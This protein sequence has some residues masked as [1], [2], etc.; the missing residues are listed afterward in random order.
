MKMRDKLLLGGF[1]IALVTYVLG[2]SAL[3]G[4]R[5][6]GQ[7]FSLLRKDTLP[8]ASALLELKRALSSVVEGVDRVITS[9]DPKLTEDVLGDIS[10]AR[11]CV[12]DH[13]AQSMRIT[14]GEPQGVIEIQN[15]ADGII[16]LAEQALKLVEEGVE[17]PSLEEIQRRIHSE[18]QALAGVLDERFSANMRKLGTA[19]EN[20]CRAETSGARSVILAIAAA[21][22][23]AVGFAYA[24]ANWI[25][26]PIYLLRRGSER[27]GSG[28]FAHRV[29]IRTGDEIEQLASEFNRMAA[30]VAEA[31]SS[32]EKKVA[33]RTADV[34]KI[35]EQL[36]TEIAE[37][38]ETE[39]ALGRERDLLRT[40]IDTSPDPIY[41]K[42]T[43]SRFLVGNAAVARL[44]G[45]KTPD[46]LIGKTDFDFYPEELA[47]FYHE[48]ERALFESGQPIIGR[49]EPV[50][51]PAG[52]RTWVSTSKVLLRDSGG[53]I[54][55]L[56]GSGRDIT[57]QK[58]AEEALRNSEALYHSLVESLP[59]NVFRKDSEGRFT[60]GNKLFC[61]TLGRPLREFIG[62]TDFDFYPRELAEKYRQDDR[63]VMETGKVFEDIEE[64]QK[65]DGERIYVQVLKSPVRNFSG[66]VIGTQGIFWDVTDRKKAEEAL[67]NS[68]A[69][70]HSLVE[71]LPL[72]IFRK[73]S[74]GGF[75]FGNKLFCETLGKPP[76]EFIGKTDFD[77]YP[78]ELAEKYRRDDK[79]VMETGEVFEDVEEHQK[80][81]GEKIYVQVVKTPVQNFSGEIIGTQGIFWDVTDRKRA[82]EALVYERY[83]LESLMDNLPDSI[84][85]KD[86]RSRFTRINR[87]LAQRFGLSDPQGALGKTDF[88]FFTE[89]H[90]RPAFEDE[91]EIV[92][93]G[94]P[95]V[96]KEEKETWPNGRVTWVSTTKLPLRDREGRIV[97]TF[98]VSRDITDR[99]RAEEELSKTAAELARSNAE[100]EQFA[101]VASHDLQEP[102]R[103][104]ASYTQLLAKRYSRKLSQEADEFIAYIVDGATRMQNLIGALLAYSRVGT[105]GKSFEPTD[106][107]VA[108][109]RAL[110]NLQL[111]IEES[112]AA[113]TKDPLPT[114]NADPLQLCQLFQNLVSNAIKFRGT[115]RPR[116]HVSAERNMNEWKFSVRDNGIGIEPGYIGRIFV[117]FQRLHSRGEYPGTGIG[118]AICKKI[119]ERH[120]GR[121]WVES[122]PGEGSTF[123]FT[124][125][126]TG[127]I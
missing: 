117:V 92:R 72:N 89:D 111:A 19:E 107:N 7:E 79:K 84:Y 47:R 50:V 38:R 26:K 32:L 66:E 33:D 5:R 64:H 77:F 73:D 114:V 12:Q 67:R 30:R 20:L 65:P 36:K 56:V 16:A 55:G 110:A 17:E 106:C 22:A 45:A 37:R 127:G 41:V 101:Y 27:I 99:K 97:G 4:Y 93:S 122:K 23:L 9:P 48:A 25:V 60:F 105:R 11:K 58:R 71:S 74:G 125:P 39:E 18:Q 113:V 123:Y 83:L 80:P 95:L 68:Q 119:A 54:I 98:G 126:A 116:I 2:F 108:L 42:D 112:G 14:E 75:T 90:A 78:K 124:I 63:T 34:S 62:K 43:K 69:L 57:E 1:A 94:E 35:N 120:G 44:M 3:R 91:Q 10:Q 53:K 15:R 61:E 102:L 70:Y 51:D 76:E 13:T 46:E 31:Y 6:I 118:L 88:D 21:F 86:A 59:L 121:I 29:E 96:A 28:D 100:L 81:G 104:M 82:E 85:F 8:V 115:D 40:V 87:A 52:N 109:E 49:E 24:T 103:M